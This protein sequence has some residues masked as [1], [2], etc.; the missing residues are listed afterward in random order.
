[1]IRTDCEWVRRTESLVATRKVGHEDPPAGLSHSFCCRA[2]SR[3]ARRRRAAMRE[4]TIRHCPLRI[5]RPDR[6]SLPRY[7]HPGWIRAASP[8]GGSSSATDRCGPTTAC[9]GRTAPWNAGRLRCPLTRFVPAGHPRPGPGAVS[10]SARAPTVAGD[11]GSPWDL[12]RS[13]LGWKQRTVYRAASPRR[14]GLPG[15]CG[16]SLRRRPRRRCHPL[17]NRALTK[18]NCRLRRRPRLILSQATRLNLCR[19][20]KRRHQNK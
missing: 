20:R 13:L 4:L 17:R 7:P 14:A 15:H 6:H 3:S 10:C 8:V 19:W 1:M 11:A 9:P 12:L 18:T 2:R 16:K 5:W